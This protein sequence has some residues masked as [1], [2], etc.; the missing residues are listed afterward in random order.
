MSDNGRFAY[1]PVMDLDTGRAVGLEVRRLQARDV[2]PAVGGS[3]LSSRQV[4]DVDAGVTVTAALSAVAAGLD[5]ALHLDVLGETVLTAREVLGRLPVALRRDGHL[6]ALVLEIGGL[7]TAA[8]AADLARAVAELREA[9]FLVGLDAVETRFGLEVVAAVAPDLAKLGPGLVGRLDADPHARTVAAAVTAVCDSAGVPVAADGVTTPE[10][11][12]VL[13]DLGVRLAE[14]PL[15][16][17]PR[18]EPVTAGVL[19]PWV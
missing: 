14:G 10:Q 15:L 6:P 12:D 13:L 3:V 8:S 18:P 7:P 4:A 1:E 16:A 2:V 5:A 9:G 11:L 17:P 19:L